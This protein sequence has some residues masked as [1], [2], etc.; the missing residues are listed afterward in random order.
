[1]KKL[2]LITIA[3]C[4]FAACDNG[5]PSKHLPPDVMKKLL[6]DV[7]TAEVYSTYHKDTVNKTATKNV[8]SLSLYY[9][10]ILEHYNITQEEFTENLAWYQHNP[11]NLDSVYT[12]LV[13]GITAMQAKTNGVPAVAP[14]PVALPGK[15]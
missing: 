4:S 13:T 2:L 12:D 14:V 7:H 15:K 5:T 9:K 1:M 10:S 8:D 6:M 3:A 11:D